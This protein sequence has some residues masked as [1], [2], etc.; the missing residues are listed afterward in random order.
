MKSDLIDLDAKLIHETDKA[1]LFDFE[2]D[3]GVWLPKS[4][5]EWDG[6]QV[7]L[8]ETLAIEKGLV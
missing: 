4:Q 5:H 3:E 8:P 2:M 6:R 1:R 7:T